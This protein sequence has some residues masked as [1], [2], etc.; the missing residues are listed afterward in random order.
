M[1]NTVVEYVLEW[2]FYMFEIID[3]WVQNFWW[4]NWTINFDFK[5]AWGTWLIWLICDERMCCMLSLIIELWGWEINIWSYVLVFNEFV[6]IDLVKLIIEISW[7]VRELIKCLN[8]IV[9]CEICL[10]L[11][12]LCKYRWVWSNRVRRY[13]DLVNLSM[14]SFMRLLIN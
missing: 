2:Q 4:L 10:V 13:F 8:N 9:E 12:D 14:S 5:W 3:F 7:L 6:L 1:M 11:Y